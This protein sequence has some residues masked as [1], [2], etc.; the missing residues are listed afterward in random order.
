MYNNI[1]IFTK[2]G[3]TNVQYTP[4][5]CARLTVST[6]FTTVVSCV[7]TY[8]LIN[9]TKLTSRDYE[10]TYP[11]SIVQYTSKVHS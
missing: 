6:L 2:Y 9:A 10:G 11:P 8:I 1:S 5:E 3:G 7:D 4:P